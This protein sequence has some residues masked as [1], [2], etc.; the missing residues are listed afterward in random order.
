MHKTAARLVE[1]AALKAGTHGREKRLRIRR[2]WALDAWKFER[3]R[4][5]FALGH[6]NVLSGK[7]KFFLVKWRIG[8]STAGG[9]FASPL[10]PRARSAPRDEMR[11]KGFFPSTL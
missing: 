10:T 7:A 6:G 8:S 4:M 11:L 3:G 1:P 2:H 9:E 5:S